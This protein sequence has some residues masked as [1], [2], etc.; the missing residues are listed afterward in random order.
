MPDQTFWEHRYI[1]HQTGW[2]LGEV[3]P[4]LKGFA[5]SLHDKSI[6]ILI[7]GCGNA[8]EAAYL[9]EQ[10]FTDITIL[11]IA[12]QPLKAVKE[13][14]GDRKELKLVHANFFDFT[15]QFDLIL[16]QTFLCALDP[17][18][19][20]AYMHKMQ[21]LLKPSGILAG[22]LF[23]VEYEKQGP[24]FGGTEKEYR[25]HMKPYL[26]IIKMEPCEN[27]IQPRMNTELFF[28]ARPKI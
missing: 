12:E 28:M 23:N 24:P 2:D 3:S 21:Q 9:L 15:G 8:Y 22:V 5:E 20:A 14:L 6:S 1:N 16:E 10:G 13:L 26:N 17:S 25:Q 4:P 27:S 7:P 11:D 18:D 19:R